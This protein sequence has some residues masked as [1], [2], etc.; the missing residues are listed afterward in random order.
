MGIALAAGLTFALVVVSVLIHYEVLYGASRLM[1]RLSIPV[2]ARM[3]VVIAACVTAH[4]LEISLFA[5]AYGLMDKQLGM[6][7][8][9]GETEGSALDLFYFSATTFTTL[10]FGDINP[11]G[12]LRIVAGIESLTGLVLIGWSASFTYLSM[13]DFWEEHRKRGR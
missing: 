9:S 11:F 13:Q 1:P 10:G 2:R 8:I 7:T 3:P 4:V 6:G 12:A 5:A